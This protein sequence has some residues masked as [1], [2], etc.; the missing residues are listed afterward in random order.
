[1]TEAVSAV[2][3][4]DVEPDAARFLSEEERLAARKLFLPVLN[5]KKG[6]VD[7]QAA[8]GDDGAFGALLLEGM[9]M[10]RLR[11]GNQL[12]VRLLGPT[13]MLSLDRQGQSMLLAESS[14]SATAPTRLAVLGDEVLAGIQRWPRLAAGIYVRNAEQANRL[15][16]QLAICQLPRVDQ[17]ILSL[18]WLLAESWGHVGSAGT[19]LPV[20]LTH[21]ALGALIG[22][23]R[24][25]VT[26]AL[27]ELSERGA[28]VRQE[29]GWLLLEAPEEPVASGVPIEQPAPLELLP[30][31]W[32]AAGG[33]AMAPPSHEELLMAIGTLREEHAR[34]RDRVRTQLVRMQTTRERC[35]E[36]R[37]S[38]VQQ[39]LTRRAPS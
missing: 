15:S 35:H 23:R 25:T 28:I 13:D 6:P 10:H 16:A 21:D 33:T 9:L 38:I 29:R 7:V 31:G 17:R 30:T 36:V 24:P 34:A 11:I 32:D 2:R 22:A 27:G 19:T 1:L 12:T 18:L 39:G 8:L 20:S 4:L 3:L 37:R 14:Y 5:L 26:L